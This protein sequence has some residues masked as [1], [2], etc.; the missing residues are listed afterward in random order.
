M[1]IFY[2]IF[3]ESLMKH[4]CKNFYSKKLMDDILMDEAPSVR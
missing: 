4:G 3:G 1:P 2:K